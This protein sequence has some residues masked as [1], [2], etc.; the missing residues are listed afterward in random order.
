LSAAKQ[1]QREHQLQNT[2]QT[3]TRSGAVTDVICQVL[4]HRYSHGQC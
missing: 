1:S 3:V 2:T 4:A